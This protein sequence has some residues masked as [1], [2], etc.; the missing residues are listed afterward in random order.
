MT[1]NRRE[2]I[3]STGACM[4]AAA[5]LSTPKLSFGGPVM[6]KKLVYITLPGGVDGFSLTPPIGDPAY[7]TER[8]QFAIARPDDNGAPIERRA[9]YLSDMF[10]MHPRTPELYGMFQRGELTLFPNVSWARYG[11]QTGSHF[12]EIRRAEN[13]MDRADNGSMS[14]TGWVNRLLTVLEGENNPGAI[15]ITG[16]PVLPDVLHGPE[17]TAVY[18]PPG[19]T[20][21]DQTNLRLRQV[22]GNR[23]LARV[24]STGYERRDS[25]NRA[26]NGSNVNF[27]MF[28][29]FWGA[30]VQ[31]QIAGI[32]MATDQQYAPS[33]TVMNLDGWD[34]HTYENNGWGYP[35]SR[36]A[37]L[38]L[39]IGTL[40][41]TLKDRNM[42]HETL[43]A[44]GTEFGRPVRHNGGGTDHGHG[45]TGAIIT[46]NPLLMAQ[47]GQGIVLNGAW[48]GFA[49]RDANNL[50]RDNG[51]YQNILRQYVGAHFNLTAA[52]LEFVLPSLP[53]A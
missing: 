45:W 12:N 5:A 11:M 1:L 40:V 36:L 39:A 25:L 20:T 13:G 23:T 42:F 8:A 15:A 31:A 26:L 30:H 33:I 4:G 32:I 34:W 53:S 17:V 41:Q 37:H 21:S 22:M 47:P 27:N 43:I 35:A 16:Q 10:G 28:S 7:Y 50:I 19:A 29:N 18:M 38:S 6:A 24:Y 51:R 44:I 3:K 52:E 49:S 9:L 48:P 2:F 46:G 14:L